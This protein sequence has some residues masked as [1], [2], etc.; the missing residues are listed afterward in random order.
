MEPEVS[1]E[2][3]QTREHINKV[4]LDGLRALTQM[5]EEV[6]HAELTQPLPITQTCREAM[7]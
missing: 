1:H 7:L 5:V 4:L 2:I 6:T 3:P